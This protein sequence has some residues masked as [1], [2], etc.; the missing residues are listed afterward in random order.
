MHPG[1]WPIPGISKACSWAESH[2]VHG[3][4]YIVHARNICMNSTR[5][6]Q[7]SRSLASLPATL[8]HPGALGSNLAFCLSSPSTP[9]LLLTCSPKWG[10][11][12]ATQL[13]APLHTPQ[14]WRRVSVSPADLGICSWGQDRGPKFLFVLVRWESCQEAR[15]SGRQDLGQEAGKFPLA[16]SHLPLRQVHYWCYLQVQ[17]GHNSARMEDPPLTLS[18]PGPGLRWGL[19]PGMP[20]NQKLLRR[21]LT[22][23]VTTHRYRILMKFAVQSAAALWV[24]HI[25]SSKSW[26]D[27]ESLKEQVKLTVAQQHRAPT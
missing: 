26:P 21:Q 2:R 23:Q 27:N 19:G 25:A 24:I 17:L 5:W 16:W 12:Q 11:G 15:L 14:G 22:S 7:A 6:L 8:M 3:R 9:P 20:V 10:K 1:S 18:S 13:P 4:R